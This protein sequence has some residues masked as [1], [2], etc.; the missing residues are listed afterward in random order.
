MRISAPTRIPVWAL[1][2][3]LCA[4]DAW[5]PGL[6]RSGGGGGPPGQPS[7]AQAAEAA[8][9]EAE[10]ALAYARNLS[11]GLADLARLYG[12]VETLAGRV[13]QLQDEQVRHSEDAGSFYVHTIGLLLTGVLTQVVTAAAEF[14]NELLP[15]RVVTV[16]YGDDRGIWHERVLVWLADSARPSAR[17]TSLTPDGDVYE[18]E[19]ASGADGDGPDMAS[20]TF[21]AAPARQRPAGRVYRFRAYQAEAELL[22]LV[23]TARRAAR[24]ADLAVSEPPYYMRG[25]EVLGGGTTVSF[26]DVSGF[27]RRMVRKAPLAAAAV[28]GGGGDRPPVDD[29]DDG[30]EDGGAVGG[31]ATPPPG[32]GARVLTASEAPPPGMSWIAAKTVTGEIQKGDE[33]T[34]GVGDVLW[35]E[36][37][38]HGLSSGFIVP[39]ELVPTSSITR[40]TGDGDDDARLLGALTRAREGR[41]RRDF[42]ESVSQMRQEVLDDFPPSGERSY[43]WLCE[44]IAEH[45]GTPDGRQPKWMT[46]SSCAKDSAAVHFHDL[47]GLYIELAQTYDQVDGSNLA[48]ME[49]VARTYQLAEETMGSMKV[50]GVEH[51]IGRSNQSARRGVAVAPGLAKC[52]TEQLAKETEIQ[53]QRRKAREEKSASSGKRGQG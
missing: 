34:P 28:G 15:G 23:R 2:G 24:D 13:R 19:L 29:G 20:L 18:E 32:L 31:T 16:H 10:R 47:L 22:Q 52:A 49:V 35:G 41:R 50:E 5:W 40:A 1:L 38:F 39:M 9:R 3:A 44:H 30:L 4:L 14:F 36:S 53:K 8:A 21:G 46:E 33:I 27:Y 6:V 7:S 37:G 26:G 17:W 42:R 45:G 48:C 11:G 12:E 51:N 43:K 25:A